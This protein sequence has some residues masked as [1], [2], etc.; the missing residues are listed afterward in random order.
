MANRRHSC[1][2]VA[3]KPES[4]MTP[5]IEAQSPHI[6]IRPVATFMYETNQMIKA[7]AMLGILA[8]IGYYLLDFS[9]HTH[10]S[11]I[12]KEA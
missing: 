3:K 9:P 7:E 10:I 12:A 8:S 5:K 1:N 6:K 11:H 4:N 2:I